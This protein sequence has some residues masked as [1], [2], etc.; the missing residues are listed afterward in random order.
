MGR[1]QSQRR[2]AQRIQRQTGVNKGTNERFIGEMRQSKSCIC[3]CIQRS[4]LLAAR[5]SSAPPETIAQ[6]E[7]RAKELCLPY[8][9]SELDP[10]QD[11][12]VPVGKGIH[13][14]SLELY[15]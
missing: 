7:R 3:S 10:V 11:C 13:K 4:L 1:N 12:P 6:G 9:I 14:P 8:F 2:A 15:L 5:L